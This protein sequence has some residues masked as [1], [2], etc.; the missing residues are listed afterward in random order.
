MFP[1]RVLMLTFLI[2]APLAVVSIDAFG[3]P[4]D[5]AYFTAPIAVVLVLKGVSIIIRRLRERRSRVGS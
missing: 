5:V 2:A 3:V 1:D 4:S